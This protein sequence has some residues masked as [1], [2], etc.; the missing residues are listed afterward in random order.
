[1]LASNQALLVATN[2][3]AQKQRECDADLARIAGLKED[4]QAVTDE[5]KKL[6]DL[7]R[8]ET[9]C[10]EELRKRQ[11]EQKRR[12]LGDLF[13]EKKKNNKRR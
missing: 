8:E 7:I 13:V 6:V 3:K 9:T 5:N 11:L 10:L 12:D 4:L 1:L 2:H